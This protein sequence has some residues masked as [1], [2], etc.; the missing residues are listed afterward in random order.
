MRY[1]CP[2]FLLFAYY[3]CFSQKVILNETNSQIN[4]ASDF[5]VFEDKSARLTFEE[6]QKL[7]FKKNNKRVLFF[8]FTDAAYWLKLE[9]ENAHPTQE[10]WVL[11]WD[12]SLMERIDFYI[13]DETD[14]YQVSE[15]GALSAHQKFRYFEYFPNLNLSIKEGQTKVIYV[16][17]KSE[18]G[19]NAEVFISTPKIYDDNYSR[20]LFVQGIIIGLIFLRLFYVLYISTFA[21]KEKEFRRYSLLQIIRSL[22]F[23]GLNSVLGGI[24]TKDPYQAN[25]INFLAQH[26]APIGLVLVI[27]AI[28]PIHRL[29]PIINIILHAIIIS[30]I[31]LV[32]LIAF[33]YRWQWLMASTYI[34]LFIE[35]FVLLLF[36]YSFLRKIP[37]NKYYSIPFLL[38]IF[39]YLFVQLRLVFG[40]SYAW[41]I[42]FANFCFVAE[43]LVFGFFLGRIIIDYEKSRSASEKQLIL[44]QERT[45]QL[46][47][48]DT[49]KTNFFTNISHEFRTPL[50]LLISPLIDLQ[51]EFPK[52]EIFRTM[53]R[54]G[55]RL[56]ALINQLLD[57][58]KLEA[59]QMSVELSEVELVNFFRT[60]TSSF[61]SLAQGRNI[62]F[63]VSQNKHV[64]SALIDK[65]KTEK[66]ITNLLSNAFKFTPENK[67][68]EITIAYLHKTP[69]TSTAKAI[70]KVKDEGIGISEEKLSKIFDRFY[71]VDN[72][73]SREFEGTGIGLALVKE[74]VSVLKGKISVES[75]ENKGTCFTLELPVEEINQ[76]KTSI[77]DNSDI[78]PASKENKLSQAT[79]LS[80]LDIKE[81]ILLIVDDNDDIRRYVKSIFEKEYKV[82][83]ANNGKEGIR[84]ANEQIPD[85]IISDLMMPEMDG[86]EFCQ[87]IKS[88]E[89]TS[90]IPVVMLTAKATVDSRIQGLELG[91]DDYLIKPFNS[92]EIQI[93]IKNLIEK[94]ERLRQYYTRN[95]TSAKPLNNTTN[96]LDI[97]FL[98]RAKDIVERH[99]GNNLFNAEQLSEEMHLSQSQ[100]LRKL[101][102]LTNLTIVEFIRQYRLERA[103]GLLV[104]QNATVSEVALQV[105]FENMSYFA[106][107]FHDQY[108][109][110]PSDY[111]N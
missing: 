66:I 71:Q 84:K 14:R 96:T 35:F 107:V 70:I 57:L 98:Q 92:V 73:S 99:L 47:E 93:R 3:S 85:I 59:H 111:R 30:N 64:F 37:F 97:A 78:K 62:A 102:A 45:Q 16:R 5:S 69:Q 6:A 27:R 48:L 24:F 7:P 80:A 53:Y 26:I 79:V 94:Q 87:N 11:K 72:S 54:N 44:N 50:T 82:I 39:S 106:K 28:L 8:P 13:P 60:L 15:M 34:F 19:H 88:D 36:L 31:I 22:A 75:K 20:A 108:G 74:L 61:S 18:R 89:K 63:E 1:L 29:H 25:I 90:H 58:S 77:E 81:N 40:L 49:L 100:L 46:K 21:V 104:K 55:E 33:D 83:E 109:V 68:I 95:L 23:L 43:L 42:P 76:S 10:K 67:R 17:V 51:K 9:I 101:K 110:L 103:A 32:I 12:N 41:V 86:F 4:V 91:A 65:D 105:G 2:I 56:L 52:R 38:G